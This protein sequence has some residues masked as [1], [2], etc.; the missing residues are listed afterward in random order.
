MGVKMGFV[1]MNSLLIVMACR[2]SVCIQYE[3]T[4]TIP[5]DWSDWSG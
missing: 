3:A 5:A 1:S 2:P 4:Y